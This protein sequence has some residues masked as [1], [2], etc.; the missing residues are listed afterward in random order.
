MKPMV[1]YQLSS[2]Y[3]LLIL[4]IVIS[5]FG[6]KELNTSIK[7]KLLISLVKY[8]SKLRTAKLWPILKNPK[9]KIYSNLDEEE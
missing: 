6:E 1:Q 4:T 8:P 9:N 2:K 5:V 3:I 7:S